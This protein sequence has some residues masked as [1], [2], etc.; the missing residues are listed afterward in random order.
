MEQKLIALD[1]EAGDEFGSSVAISGGYAMVGAPAEDSEA[2]N[3]GAVYVYRRN[4]ATGAWEQQR[5]LTITGSDDNTNF[6][7]GTDMHNQ[8]AVIGAQRIPG[9]SAVTSG[10]YIF[11][12]ENDVWTQ[13]ATVTPSNATT[14]LG[15]ELAIHN[16]RVLLGRYT[17]N[18]SGTLSGSAY[19]FHRNGSTWTE[20]AKLTASD[21]EAFD[22]FAWDVAL[23][24]DYA[25][26][27]SPSERAGETG[28]GA[29]YVF[30]YTEGDGWKQ[31]A[32]LRAS[33][34]REE[35]YFG[36]SVAVTDGRLIVGARFEDTGGFG[37][38]RGLRV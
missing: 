15:G 37:R 16:D 5:K 19:V 2:S 17:D 29:V 33:D 10:G 4:A 9:N 27:G 1:N 34:Q 32:K 22:Y 12:L 26:I 8:Y 20:M 25:V 24:G 28:V 35:M 31:T 30:H 13:Q 36:W 14:G 18:T 3:A 11:Y 6:G 7:I 38:R 23:H 21:S